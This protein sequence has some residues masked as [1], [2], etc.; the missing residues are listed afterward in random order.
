MIQRVQSLF[1][2]VS[3]ILLSV[4]SCLSVAEIMIDNNIY[5]YKTFGIYS[6]DGY[7]ELIAHTYPLFILI[8]ISTIIIFIS[9]FLFK[10]RLLQLRLCL[11]SIFLQSGIYGLGYFYIYQLSNKY[12]ILIHYSFAIIIPLISIILVYMAMRAIKKDEILIKSLDRIR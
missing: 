12:E 5:S 8:I 6:Q 11:I 3:V 9:I 4:L 10:K 2:L 1:L 7:Y